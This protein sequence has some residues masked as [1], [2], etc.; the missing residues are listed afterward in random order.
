VAARERGAKGRETWRVTSDF[1]DE[2]TPAP[3]VTLKPDADIGLP[4]PGGPSS[5]DGPSAN[6]SPEAALPGRVGL[7]EGSA[8]TSAE[9]RRSEEWPIGVVATMGI[10]MVFVLG[11]GF[12]GRDGAARAGW[13]DFVLGGYFLN[14]DIARFG[15][16]SFGWVGF[17]P[18]AATGA[19]ALGFFFAAR[20]SYLLGLAMMLTSVALATLTVL[21]GVLGS[22]DWPG[23]PTTVVVWWLG[24]ASLAL[25]AWLLFERRREPRPPGGS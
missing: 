8:P 20:R 22:V 19:F 21:L 15:A 18:P 11:A 2:V 7:V 24:T 6:E 23:F 1:Y 10:G 14:A 17:L 3:V 9:A 4:P 5:S 12:L 13:L 16:Q 25:A